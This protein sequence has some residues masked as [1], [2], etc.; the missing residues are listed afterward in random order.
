[1]F[2]KFLGSA[3]L[4]ASVSL[5]AVASHYDFVHDSILPKGSQ[6]Q[7]LVVGVILN[8]KD[9]SIVHGAHAPLLKG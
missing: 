2:A 4:S 8:K 1:M 7:F 5:G 6:G 9:G 3:L